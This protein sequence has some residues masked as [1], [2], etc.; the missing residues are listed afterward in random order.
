MILQLD[1]NPFSG[2]K[3]SLP[4]E[5]DGCSSAIVEFDRLADRKLRHDA[6]IIECMI[7]LNSKMITCGFKPGVEDFGVV[8]ID[9]VE[10]SRWLQGNALL[11]QMFVIAQP[12]LGFQYVDDP[13]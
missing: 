10:V 7:P 12:S 2:C 1:S 5:A 8:R 6:R 3:L 13:S 11:T 4:Y 9:V